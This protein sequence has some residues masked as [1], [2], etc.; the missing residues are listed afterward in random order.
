MSAFQMWVKYIIQSSTNTSKYDNHTLPNKHINQHRTGEFPQLVPEWENMKLKHV[1]V[2]QMWPYLEEIS[3]CHGELS[4]G[5]K[6]CWADVWEGDPLSLV[7][8][9][10]IIHVLVY[11]WKNMV[12]ICTS[13]PEI[14]SSR[15]VLVP[16]LGVVKHWHFPDQY[17]QN[18]CNAM[19]NSLISHTWHSYFC[20]SVA[21]FT[22]LFGIYYLYVK[23]QT[24]CSSN[25]TDAAKIKILLTSAGKILCWKFS[26]HQ[27]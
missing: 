24:S 8:R 20:F 7:F 21:F 12:Y 22:S 14:S 2:T 25:L 3:S 19:R 6:I 4:T 13:A 27:K 11:P 26:F 18:M 15:T 1:S 5:W 17:C 10:Q 16:P 23:Y 9:P